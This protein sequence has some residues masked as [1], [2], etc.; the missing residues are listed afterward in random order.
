MEL[1]LKV[2]ICQLPDGL[3]LEHPAW[4]D[5]LRTIETDRP[6]IVVLN[7]MPFGPWIAGQDT[8]DPNL[9]NAAV[10]V[11]ERAIPALQRLPAA[12][13]SSRPVLGPRKLSNEAF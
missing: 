11:H 7:E 10:E 13:L 2:S 12:V 3:S 1:P 5:L 4:S 6:D 8:F 9:G